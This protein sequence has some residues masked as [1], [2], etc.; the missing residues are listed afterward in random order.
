MKKNLVSCYLNEIGEYERLDQEKEL[1]LLKKAQNGDYDARE[2]II[3]S[4]LGLVVMIAKKFKDRGPSLMDLIGE[5]NFGLIT[6]IERFNVNLGFRFSTY[7]SWWIKQA[8]RKAII[9]ERGIKLPAYKCDILKKVNIYI[10]KVLFEKGRVPDF[11]EIS[12]TLNIPLEKINELFEEVHETVSLD[13][14]IGD[15]IVLQDVL[16]E[17]IENVEDQIIQE[18]SK[19]QINEIVNKLSEREKIILKK[20]FGFDGDQVHSLA[21]IGKTFNITRERV[22]QVEQKTLK[23]LKTRYSDILK[24]SYY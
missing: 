7:A 9:L 19:E 16:G 12:Q 18:I 22:R 1:E 4:N 21:E 11:S 5:G 13:D 23:K 14:P 15:G 3:L 6:A 24:G 8:I 17:K 10:S 2:K 20:R